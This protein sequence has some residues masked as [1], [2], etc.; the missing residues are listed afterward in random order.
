MGMGPKTFLEFTPT[1]LM[2]ICILLPLNFLV[3]LG[4]VTLF[5]LSMTGQFS[6]ITSVMG[7]EWSFFV[8]I[9]LVILLFNK[10]NTEYVARMNFAT[11]TSLDETQ[12]LMQ[13]TL[14]RYFGDTLSDKMLNEGGEIKGENKW[15]SI[16]FTDIKSYSTITE[17]M[18][19]EVT[20]EFLNQYFTAM[21]E[22]I[23]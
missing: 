11:T 2:V 23:K 9:P 14:R 3:T 6:Q 16:S 15:V 22:V 8:V 18:S 21:H 19:P 10:Y 17:N 4:T 5:L 1:L 13:Q 20:L 12:D 7:V